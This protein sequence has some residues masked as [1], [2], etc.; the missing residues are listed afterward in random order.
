[1]DVVVAD[2]VFLLE[3]KNGGKNFCGPLIF[4]LFEENKLQIVGNDV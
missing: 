1:M 2:W 4:Y 3:G